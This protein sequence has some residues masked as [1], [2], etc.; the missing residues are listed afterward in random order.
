LWLPAEAGLSAAFFMTGPYRNVPMRL[1]HTLL[2]LVS[3][4]VLAQGLFRKCCPIRG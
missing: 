4:T 3:G 2:G 1:P